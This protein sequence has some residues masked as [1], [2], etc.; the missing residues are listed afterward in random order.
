MQTVGPLQVGERAAGEP[1]RE[2]QQLIVQRPLLAQSRQHTLAHVV[3][4]PAGELVVQVV[5]GLDELRRDR[6]LRRCRWS[7][8]TPDC[9][10]S[11]HHEDVVAAER[12]EL[13]ALEDRVGVGRRDGEAD[14]S[15][16]FRQHVRRARQQIV[17]ER[18]VAGLLPQPRLDA[19]GVLARRAWPRAADRRRSGSRGRSARGRPRCAAATRSPSPRAER[20]RCESWRT[21]RPGR[22]AASA[23]RTPPARPSR[24]TRGSAQRECAAYGQTAQEMSY[25]CAEPARTPILCPLAV[26]LIE[27]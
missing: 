25:T 17:D 22:R 15:R 21:T 8:A 18:R 26:A 13:D 20:G 16:H 23:P 11:P 24:C 27:C 4:R 9:R 10:A 5:G 7:S 2:P 12:H 19:R 3:E 6:P 1:Q 14:V